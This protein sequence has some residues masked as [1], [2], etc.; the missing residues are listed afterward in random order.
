[1]SDLVS[2][3]LGGVLQCSLADIL[4]F[5]TGAS[6][7]PPL[8]FP[9]PTIADDREPTDRPLVISFYREKGRLPNASTCGLQLWL[10]TGL[11][12]EFFDRAMIRSITEGTEFG[13]K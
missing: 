8:G 2:V 3:L 7:V 9:Q 11:E 4:V 10:P 12:Q 5:W 13:F 1:M 6:C